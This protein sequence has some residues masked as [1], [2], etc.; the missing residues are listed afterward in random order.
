MLVVWCLSE[1]VLAVV[2]N[3]V[4]TFANCRSIAQYLAACNSQ[5]FTGILGIR[6]AS[7]TVWN[8]RFFI[9]RIIGEAGGVEPVGRWLRH[10]HRVLPDIDWQAVGD[11]DI[12]LGDLGKCWNTKL[13]DSL[14]TQQFID[15][16]QAK[17][18][19]RSSVIDVLF[20]IALEEERTSLH[21]TPPLSYAPT[22][23]LKLMGDKSLLLPLDVDDVWETATTQLE[24]WMEAN[25]NGNSPNLVPE[26][27]N[28]TLLE[29]LVSQDV[30]QLFSRLMDGKNSLRDVAEVLDKQVDMVYLSLCPF[31]L[32]NAIVLEDRLSPVTELDPDFS[33]QPE[34]VRPPFEKTNSQVDAV[35]LATEPAGSDRKSSGK[36]ARTSAWETSPLLASNSTNG[37]TARECEQ[38]STNV[39]SEIASNDPQLDSTQ[40]RS[41]A[42]TPHSPTHSTGGGV[43][44]S[45]ASS[46]LLAQ[47]SGDGHP[48]IAYADDNS[49]DR[50]LMQKVL[51]ELGCNRVI[52]ISE[53][54]LVL[55]SL[56]DSPPD[57]VF[58]GLENAVDVC[59]QI[60]RISPL[61]HIPIVIVT[62]TD[63]VLERMRAKLAGAFGFIAKPI[64]EDDLARV[65]HRF[66]GLAQSQRSL[67]SVNR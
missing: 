54:T 46:P 57:L 58:L 19:S 62:S 43:Q 35:S 44:G 34:A 16:G 53:P 29:Q 20:D 17:S 9:G 27:A 31:I 11:P 10:L 26:I 33:Q 67:Q 7:G 23:C 59:T 25:G 48:T 6:S 18:V 14:L 60:R 4:M 45:A 15:R 61:K 52:S 21:R 30:W 56:L 22:A 39:H 36:A 49:A 24:R 42:N 66:F 13:L 55:A 65:L 5:K 51:S 28:P 50:Q 32:A 37:V 63:G 41:Y 12:P 64:S 1:A 2:L 8:I 3:V 47:A 38:R 40:N